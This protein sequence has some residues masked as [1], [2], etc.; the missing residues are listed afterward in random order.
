MKTGEIAAGVDVSTLIIILIIL[1]LFC[2]LLARNK[3]AYSKLRN[4]VL[5]PVTALA[6]FIIYYIG[7][8]DGG[9]EGVLSTSCIRSF[10][11]MC[12]M[13]LLHSDLLEVSHKLH[14]NQTYM[15]FF[16][17]IHFSAFIISILFIIQ[18]FGKQFISWL[19]LKVSCPK[20]SY[21]FFD[22]NEASV[23]LAADLM[24]EKKSRMIVF[25]GKYIRY[26]FF[27]HHKAV[28][29]SGSPHDNKSL[30]DR[31]KNTS[32][33]F[34]N[35]EYTTKNS[36]K[37]LGIAHLIHKS[38]THLFF[39][40]DDEASNIR[41]AQQV[42]EEIERESLAVKRL[43]IYINTVSENLDNLFA[44]KLCGLNKEIEINIINRYKLS[45]TELVCLYPPVDYI[46]KDTAKATALSDFNVLILGFGQVGTLALRYLIEQ[47]QFVGSTFH[48][49]VIDR[50]M[51]CKEDLFVNKYPGV[52]N[53]QIEYEKADINSKKYFELLKSKIGS[54]KYIVISLGDD[55]LNIK[56]AIELYE[57]SLKYTDTPVDLFVNVYNIK[58]YDYIKK[59]IRI[60]DKIHLFGGHDDI[61]TEDIIINEIRCCTAK[62]IHEH[63]NQDK[64]EDDK[65]RWQ[66]LSTIKKITNLSAAA[67]IYTKLQLAGLSVAD[68]N[69]LETKEDFVKLVGPERILSLAEGEHLHWNATLF[70]NGWE[71]WNLSEIT[72]D[73]SC[74]KDE[75]RKKH[76][77]LVSWNELQKVNEYFGKDYKLYDVYNVEDIFEFVK[78]GIVI[79]KDKNS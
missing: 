19:S 35:R 26:S 21:L 43:S 67:H 63:Y 16:S 51:E 75:V 44:R 65:E 31:I 7:Y 1:F 42:I 69:K 18:L 57:F 6:G 28:E 29:E 22:L 3:D 8:Q 54:L 9:T 38:E 78:E 30:F 55:R 47:G 60:A 46:E 37:K 5:I 64:A 36:L 14:G 17:V 4:W 62:R 40:S 41:M 76:A 61:F 20:Q 34:L 33:V 72:G 13:F 59:S 24:K 66:E 68:I 2:L 48:A 25:V 10:L 77:C 45:A 79:D 12:S 70:T 49:T 58:N 11:S 32:A 50:M 71:T 27:A 52:K 23:S 74:N 73:R 39:L 15:L 53:Y 56:V